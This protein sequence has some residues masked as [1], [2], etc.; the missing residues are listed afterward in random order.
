[1]G[2]VDLTH[3]V[4]QACL[5]EPLRARYRQGVIDKIIEARQ[6]SQSILPPKFV[7]AWY[8]MFAIAN[9]IERRDIDFLG[10]AA[11]SRQ[12]QILQKGRDIPERQKP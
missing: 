7:E 1:M 3:D 6:L 9:E 8:P 4:N 5:L 2:A 12:M 11:Q 10:L